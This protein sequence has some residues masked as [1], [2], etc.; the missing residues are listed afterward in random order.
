MTDL[1][2]LSLALEV[3]LLAG[4][5]MSTTTLPPVKHPSEVMVLSKIT[6][7]SLA[8]LLLLLP[9]RLSGEGVSREK[10][11]SNL[12]TPPPP[13]AEIWHGC[14]VNGGPSLCALLDVW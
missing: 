13:P 5:P 4:L 10:G 9:L 2:A 11:L 6:W 1:E 7:R 8:I 14:V 3:I 12:H